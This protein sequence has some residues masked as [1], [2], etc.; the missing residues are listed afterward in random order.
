MQWIPDT[1]DAI[2]RLVTQVG[3]WGFGVVLFFL[4]VLLILWRHSNA[5][6]NA[7]NVFLEHRVEDIAAR[8]T[9][10]DELKKQTALLTKMPSDW[11]KELDKVCKAN[12][13]PITHCANYAELK[14]ED[15][16]ARALVLKEKLD[17]DEKLGIQKLQ[18]A[19]NVGGAEP[20]GAS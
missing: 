16:L 20:L 6:V 4:G 9:T 3:P 7:V 8:Q 14:P 11:V 1:I 10:N 2:T 17:R 5:I 18:E 12:T 19:F 13:M 15:V